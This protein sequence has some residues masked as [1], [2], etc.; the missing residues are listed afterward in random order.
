MSQT[1]EFRYHGESLA[2]GATVT[3]YA[4]PD[5]LGMGQLVCET[6][7]SVNP[8]NG[9][10]LKSLS[11]VWINGSANLTISENSLNASIIKWCMGGDCMLMNEIKELDKNFQSS[12]GIVQV[13]F[14]AEDISSEGDLKALLTASIGKE[15]HTVNIH[16]INGT[17]EPPAEINSIKVDDQEI[18][19][20]STVKLNIVLENETNKLTGIQC[21]M[22]FPKG[23]ELVLNADDEPEAEMGSRLNNNEFEISSFLLQSGDYRFQII[24]CG[25][26]TVTGSNG[27]IFAVY[28]KA[29]ST[30]QP[31]TKLTGI[32]K[33][34][35]LK[36]QNNKTLNVDD[37]EFNIE[38]KEDLSG[39]DSPIVMDDLFDVYS[40]TGQEMHS[41]TISLDGV[42]HGIYVVNG[43]KIL[44]LR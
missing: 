38:I 23:L 17:P 6:N 30:L 42:Q 21:D 40:I 1:F 24:S 32:V 44:I 4:V 27:I 35:V 33:N 34:I 7:P 8:D 15:T 10:V 11:G 14:D 9:L 16:F 25:D 41:G 43:K 26:D 31:G 19:P 20:D 5:E 29:D 18:Y 39:I 13:Q 28:L 37:V 12:N 36:T 3:I 2:D 22:A